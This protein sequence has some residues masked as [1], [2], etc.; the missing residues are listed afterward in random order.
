MPKMPKPSRTGPTKSDINRIVRVSEVRD[1]AFR[2]VG[3]PRGKKI[4]P[5]ATHDRL[6]QMIVLLHYVLFLS[7]HTEAEIALEFHRCTRHLI[8]GGDVDTLPLTLISLEVFKRKL[9]D[10]LETGNI[11]ND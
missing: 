2:A 11:L 8:E 6:R 4:L 7:P 9:K 1:R 5:P 10:A 3:E